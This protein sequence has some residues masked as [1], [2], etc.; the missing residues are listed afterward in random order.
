APGGFR[1]L[2]GHGWTVLAMNLTTA[3]AWSC[4]F[5]GLT[6]IEPSI[7]NTLHSGMGP[8]TILVLAACN[9]KLAET[10]TVRRPG[11]FRYAGLALSLMGLWWVVLSGACG[12]AS[13][14][15]TTSIAGLGL[16]V[17]SGASITISLLFC[18]RLQ[19]AGVSAEM[20]TAARYIVLIAL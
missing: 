7:V 1:K 20:V 4:Y 10:T 12:L 17:V 6:H 19:D 2:R 9:V 18:K 13:A 3:L 5:F 8:L 14:N 16:L 15:L 11:Y